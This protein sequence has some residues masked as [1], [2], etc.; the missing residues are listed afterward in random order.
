MDSAMG[1]KAEPGAGMVRV[2][3]PSGPVTISAAAG[4]ILAELLAG[5]RLQDSSLMAGA[6]DITILIPSNLAVTVMATTNTS[7]PARI[8][9]DFPEIRVNPTA[10]FQAPIQAQGSINGGGPVLRL[11]ASSGVIYL[12]RIK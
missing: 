12:R 4:S 1:V 8:V 3:A 11:H 2:K 7:G 5:R 6:G 10:L 9:S